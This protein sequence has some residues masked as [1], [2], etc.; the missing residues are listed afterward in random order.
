MRTSLL[1]LSFFAG[2]CILGGG[3]NGK[4]D[5]TDSDGDGLTD[6]QEADLGSDPNSADSDGDGLED[7]TEKK[8]GTDLNAADSDG[9]SY[10]D[11]QEDMAGT[12]PTDSESVI[13]AGL[14]PYNVDKDQIVEGDPQERR[15][16]VGKS[17]VPHFILQDQFGEQVDVYDFANQ[18]KPMILDLSGAWCYWCNE[19][20]KLVGGDESSALWGYGFDDLH[21]AVSNGDI[22]WLTVLDAASSNYNAPP[23]ERTISSWYSTYPEPE[24]PIL[25]DADWEVRGWIN[26]AGWP[27]MMLVDDQMVVQAYSPDDYTVAFTAALEAAG[28]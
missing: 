7:A 12:D 14:W 24:I 11:F 28:Y 20:A 25:M 3:P 19:A 8:M 23:T 17:T 6:A 13:Y 9:D 15:I 5:K 27:T 2:G 22:Y 18:G 16:T 26:P 4:A 10:T 21:E 1:I